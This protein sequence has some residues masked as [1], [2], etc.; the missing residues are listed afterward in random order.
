[1]IVWSAGSAP[2]TGQTGSATATG[3]IAAV[4]APTAV[5][6]AAKWH[7]FNDITTS[8]SAFI[9]Y[10][11]DAPAACEAPKPQLIRT[12]LGGPLF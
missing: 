7:R 8:V 4:V 10:L 3:G 1:L 6:I 5:A 2:A 12:E 9:V 11:Q